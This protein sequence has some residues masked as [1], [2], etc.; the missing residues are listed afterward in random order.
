MRILVGAW[1]PAHVHFFKYLIP[2]LQKQGHE[3]FVLAREKEITYYL[4]KNYDIPFIE[5]SVHKTSVGGKLWD[6]IV[7]WKRTFQICRKLKP[8]LALGI[9]DFYFAQIGRLLKFKSL[10]FTDSE[11]VPIDP[12]LTFPFAT[13]IL[14]PDCFGKDLGKKHIRYKGF[15]ETA[16]LNRNYFKPDESV[17]D[18]LGVK[19]GEPYIILRF[20]SW[21]AAHDIGHGG[22][23]PERKV[24]M[25]KRLEKYGKVFITSEGGLPE[26]LREY[27][28]KIA[29]EWIH[30]ALYYATLLVGDTQTMTTESAILGTP[31]IR[32]NSFVGPDDMTN[33]IQLEKDYGL[34]YNIR[35]PEEALGKAEE[36][37]Q[38]PNLKEEWA[39]KR[40][41]FL[42]DKVDVTK[43]MSW[44]VN[45]YPKSA[46]IMKDNPGYEERFK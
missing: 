29:P 24:Q 38:N 27:Q 8:D 16:Y 10:V 23:T 20:V 35:D 21:G 15:H 1:H 2:E 4:L 30:H 9:G 42:D 44:F 45:N 18:L 5:V 22:L 3:V 39:V 40:E 43:F 46:K 25:V 26:E 7:R 33:F 36:L 34:I 32:S 37:L 14:T 28:I 31:A 12:I 13:W 6:L 11:P 19:K 17:L 41:R